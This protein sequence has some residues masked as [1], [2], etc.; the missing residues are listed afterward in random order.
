[1]KR[2]WNL[3]TRTWAYL[4][5][6]TAL[7]AVLTVALCALGGVFDFSV[8]KAQE[9]TELATPVAVITAQPQ[10][11][12]TDNGGGET[13][14]WHGISAIASKG[15]SII[16][17]GLVEV[18]YGE[19]ASFSIDA[20]AGYEL[21]DLKVDGVSV[22]SADYRV[23]VGSSYYYSFTNVTDNHSIYAVFSKVAEPTPE[24]SDEPEPSGTPYTSATDLR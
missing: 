20:W 15:G 12:E 16:P 4:G 22:P 2:P 14:I 6:G 13:G 18:D 11:S 8:D 24:P 21:T 19:D 9:T 10:V 5:G 17:S 3:N 7:L 23:L 1:M